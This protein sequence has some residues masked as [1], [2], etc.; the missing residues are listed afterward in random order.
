MT[1]QQ[2]ILKMIYEQGRNDALNL[3]GRSADMD[4]TAIIA[5]ED[6]IPMFNPEKDYTSWAAGSP[7]Y[8]MLEGEKQ[9]FTLLIPHNASHYPGVR[10][11]NNAT[12]WSIK[13]TKDPAKAKAYLAPNG[14]SGMYMKGEVCTDPNAE[15][16]EEFRG[17]TVI[18]RSKVDNNVYAPSEYMANWEIV[19]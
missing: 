1:N 17:E 19:E 5:E 4:G 7:V 9:V 6:K 12:L 3:R 14:T 8:D 11:N 15:V 13:H 18:Y 2:L 10:P 16:S